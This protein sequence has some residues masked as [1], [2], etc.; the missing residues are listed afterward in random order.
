MSLFWGY[1]T[2]YFVYKIYNMMFVCIII[3]IIIIIPFL[4]TLAKN[5][6]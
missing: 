5:I 6:I 3:I 2:P 4:I 1:P